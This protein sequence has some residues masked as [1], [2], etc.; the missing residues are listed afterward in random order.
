[1]SS[2]PTIVSRYSLD[3]IR[4]QRAMKSGVTEIPTAVLD[5]VDMSEIERLANYDDAEL[6]KFI[7]DLDKY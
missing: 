3:L 5:E 1:M 2:G 6:D 7:E 4:R